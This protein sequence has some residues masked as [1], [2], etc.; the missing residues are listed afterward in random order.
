MRKMN[1]APSNFRPLSPYHRPTRTHP[2]KP[3]S[4][5]FDL[6]HSITA[7]LAPIQSSRTCPTS[8]ASLY[9]NAPFYL[10][11]HAHS[12]TSDPFL[13]SSRPTPAHPHALFYRG[14]GAVVRWE[15]SG[16]PLRTN[17]CSHAVRGNVWRYLGKVYR[18]FPE[19]L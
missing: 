13:Q 1:A 10:Q 7:P 15:R 19:S 4:L 8:P 17:R 2:T 12:H 11:S 16:A 3:H 18:V 5:I 6:Y 14:R 9:G